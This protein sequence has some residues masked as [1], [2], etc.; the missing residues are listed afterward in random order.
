MK[1]RAYGDYDA[2]EASNSSGLGS[3]DPSQTVQSEK[4][5]ADLN[6]LIERF[7]V[8][9]LVASNVPMPSLSDYS[10]VLDFSSAMQAIVKGRESFA[11]MPAKVRARFLNDPQLFLEFCEN[12]DNRAEA[13]AL[14][15]VEKKAEPVKAPPIEVRVVPDP[16]PPAS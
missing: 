16:K 5:D 12:A 9:E 14:G 11:A 4:E 10:E 6:V 2:V 1:C 15:L 3:F 13:I 8:G 7:G